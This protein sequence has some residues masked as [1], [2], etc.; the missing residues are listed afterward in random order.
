MRAR[1]MHC[2]HGH[3]MLAE[4]AVAFD[5]DLKLI[6]VMKVRTR[7]PMWCGCGQKGDRLILGPFWRYKKI[8]SPVLMTARQ[9]AVLDI[10]FRFLV[11]SNLRH[12]TSSFVRGADFFH[13]L[14]P[15]C[16]FR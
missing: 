6:N 16:N 5:D 9:R 15:L 3:R 14:G 8:G 11:R 10:G 2:M 1:E 12:M 4:H 13:Q 7:D